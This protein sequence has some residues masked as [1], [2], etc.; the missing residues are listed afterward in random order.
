MRLPGMV[1][2]CFQAKKI[3]STASVW[4]PACRELRL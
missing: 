1:K 4:A 3:E 2:A